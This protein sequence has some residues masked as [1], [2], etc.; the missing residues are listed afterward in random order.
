MGMVMATLIESAEQSAR[1][2]RGAAQ[3]A[4][5]LDTAQPQANTRETV[6]TDPTWARQNEEAIRKQQVAVQA[7]EPL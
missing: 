3:Q 5:A 1:Q 2:R 4:A 7:E 6:R